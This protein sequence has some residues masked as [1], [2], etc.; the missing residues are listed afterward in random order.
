[1][2]HIED[3]YSG[4]FEKSKSGDVSI[5]RQEYSE[6]SI[7]KSSHLGKIGKSIYS[8]F[9]AKEDHRIN[10]YEKGIYVENYEL[11][12]KTYQMTVYSSQ[13]AVNLKNDKVRLKGYKELANHTYVKAGYTKRYGII[14]LYDDSKKFQMILQV[15]GKDSPEQIAGQ[16]LNYLAIVVASDEQKEYDKSIWDKI[17]DKV[18]KLF[19]RED[20]PEVWKEEAQ[21]KDILLD[22]V[23]WIS[24]FSSEINGRNCH[25]CGQTGTCCNG[26]TPCLTCPNDSTHKT[27][28]CMV[29]CRDSLQTTACDSC[30][31]QVICKTG[32]CKTNNCCYQT[33]L[34][35]IEQF[36][37]TTNRNQAIDIATLINNN[38]WKE[39][40]DLQAD[41]EKFTEAV[42]YIDST[43]KLGKPVLIGVHYK[44]TIDKP[45]NA[46]KATIHYMVIVGKIHKDNKEY[47][48]LYDPGTQQVNEDKGK[49]TSN[50]LEVDK[51]KNMI[52]GTYKDK[53]YT[54]TEI[55][56]NL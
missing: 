10:L 46:N 31:N 25:W 4:Y 30:R 11:E 23:R 33:A 21:N 49:A 52:Y 42:A 34:A 53:P 7:R 39:Q 14:V 45:Y 35:M 36:G 18:N 20:L 15:S 32:I 40:S 2:D 27:K 41:A 55:R 43:L 48:C 5:T 17:K 50:L 29:A 19:S 24:Q 44:N 16:W 12:G 3:N 22:N 1:M 28:C 6:W 8:K 51:T 54:I 38:K 37:V 47:Y 9:N 13:P 26:G 56:K